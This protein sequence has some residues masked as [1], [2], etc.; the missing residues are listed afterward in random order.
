M[1]Q[2]GYVLI[3]V[4]VA[5]LLMIAVLSSKAP[6]VENHYFKKSIPSTLTSADICRRDLLDHVT[7]KD[8]ESVRIR[9][10]AP[11]STHTAGHHRM[12]VSAK[13]SFGGYGT[14]LA[15]DCVAKPAEDRVEYLFCGEA[16]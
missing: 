7:F 14:P 15:C 8:P 2:I 3:L 9:S 12:S 13:N 10:V 6:V 5:A 11:E 16:S 4:G 1:K